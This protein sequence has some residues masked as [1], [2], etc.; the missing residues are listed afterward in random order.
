MILAAGLGT[1]LAPFTHHHPKALA[2]VGDKTLLELTIRKLQAVGIFDIVVNV[3]H[4]ADQ[5]IRI[6]EDNKGFGSRYAI[7][8]ETA[9]VL[10]TGGGLL[11]AQ[12]LLED[13][14]NFIVINVDIISNIDLQKLISA[15]LEN[16]A[17]ATLAVQQ[18]SSNRYLLFDQQQ[19]LVG[20]K[21]EAKNEYRPELL[22]NSKIAST[23][24]FS[25]IQVLHKSIFNLIER[26]GK[27][28]LIDVYL[29]LCATQKMV[30]YDHTG[31][32]LLDVGKP[33]ALAEALK[34][35]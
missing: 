9:E 4:F 8:D 21:N 2:R 25:G 19:Q 11:F 27:F 28:S 18:R 22:D 29:D 31:D 14:E 23:K 30:G 32:V 1:R 10:E 13:S 15:H 33:E 6:L 35:I 26:R 16:N 20:W 7:S 12:P 17:V 24:A 3:H 34:Y 5:I